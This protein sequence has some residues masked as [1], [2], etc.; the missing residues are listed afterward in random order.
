MADA[1]GLEPATSGAK[2]RRSPTCATRHQ[3]WWAWR[4]SNPHDR[5]H[6]LLRPARLP[7]F[8]HTP[9]IGGSGRTCTSVAP[10]G[11][12]FTA[13]RNCFSATLPF[14][15]GPAGGSRTHMPE[16][17]ALSRRRVCHVSPRPDIGRAGGI[18]TPIVAGFEPAAYAVLLRPDKIGGGGGTRTP[19]GVTRD[20]FRDSLM[21]S[22][23]RA[24]E[25][26][27]LMAREE[28][29]LEKIDAGRTHR[30]HGYRLRL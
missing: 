9:A 16:G 27:H 24:S 30:A 22:S 17:T 28:S 20:C 12:A 11:N 15:L 1:A 14:E 7:R 26:T 4:E 8:R 5:S 23:I 13:R 10:Q 29:S 6:R 21:L 18:R 3:T 19:N 2:T 25:I